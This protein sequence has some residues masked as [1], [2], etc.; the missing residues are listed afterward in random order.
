MNEILTPNKKMQVIN[1]VKDSKFYGSISNV[2]S[3]KEA[4][5]FIDK[6]KNKFSD[7]T[8]NVSSFRVGIGEEVV[9]YA[10]DDGEPA[11]SSGPPVL[12]AIK[13][14][15]LTNAVIVITRYFGGTKLGIGGLIRAYGNTAR[16]AINKSGKKSLELYYKIKIKGD[17]NLIGTIMGQVESFSRDILNTKYD[18]NGI[19]VSLLVN[20]EVYDKFKKLLVEKTSNEVEINKVGHKY[21]VRTTD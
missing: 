21:L 1:K 2:S 9:E 8:H 15:N 6:I 20:P 19:I 13:G 5:E 16:I 10:D 4:E 11:G 18:E 12:E 14:E 17:Y 7:A 3:R